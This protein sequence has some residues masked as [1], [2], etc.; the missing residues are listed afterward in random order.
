M[1][2][3]IV[4]AVIEYL[5]TASNTLVIDGQNFCRKVLS[6]I[7]VFVDKLSLLVHY[8]DKNKFYMHPCIVK[9]TLE[10]KLS[11]FILKLPP[12]FL[13]VIAMP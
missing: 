4:I 5:S 1:Y 7:H 13:L 10:G 12:K 6:N 9:V 8:N 11:L 3:T 2:N